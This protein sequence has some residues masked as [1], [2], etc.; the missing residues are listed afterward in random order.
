LAPDLIVRVGSSPTSSAVLTFLE[1]HGQATQVVVDEGHRWKDHL[2]TADAYLSAAPAPLLER[3]SANTPRLA[4]GGWEDLWEERAARTRMVV[5]GW[6]GP[7][8]LEGEILA[9]VAETLP[10]EANLVVASSMPI[11]DLDAFGSPGSTTLNVYGNRG[12]S[13][14]DGLVSTTVGVAAAADGAVPTIGV[15][16]DLAF[17][18]DTNGLLA[19]KDLGPWAVFVVVN[20]DGGGIFHTLPV[21]EH[22]PAFSRFFTTPHGLD[23]AK[24]AELYGLPFSSADSLESFRTSFGQALGTGRPAIVEVRTHRVGTHA[25]RR[26]LVEAVVEAVELLG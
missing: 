2:S 8:L 1:E 23:F 12:A 5:D 18:H 4:A 20:N 25:Q 19:L 13:G 9:A 10:E 3:L 11:R 6:K 16:G 7:D 15:L 26:A 21:R 14:I 22:E 17:I 24:A